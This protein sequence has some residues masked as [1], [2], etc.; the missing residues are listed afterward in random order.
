MAENRGNVSA[1][2]GNIHELTAKL[3]TSADNLNK[4]SGKIASGKGTIGKLVNDEKAYNDVI[5]TLDSIQG[6]VRT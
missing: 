5:S 3:Q 6:G 4:I 1:S 2:L